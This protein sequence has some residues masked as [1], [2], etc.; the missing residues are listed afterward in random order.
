MNR[1][2]TNRISR[3]NRLSR[4]TGLGMLAW[5]AIIAV[6]VLLGTM[7]ARLLPVYID[8][9]TVKSVL[10]AIAADPE[11]GSKTPGQLR[12]EISRHF[13]T[14]RIEV[15]KPINIKFKYERSV[16]TMD[17]SYEVRVGLLYNIDAVVVFDD[18]VFEIPRR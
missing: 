10:Q 12:S 5:M 15:I 13:I 1:S 7:T 11:S 14:N 17:A 6:A 2:K 16:I 3:L 4:Q 8:N 18:M 9:M